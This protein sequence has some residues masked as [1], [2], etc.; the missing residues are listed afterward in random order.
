MEQQDYFSIGKI[1]GTHGLSGEVV[2]HHALG[3]DADLHGLKV[4]FF[5]DKKGS[6]LPYFVESVIM[7]KKQEAHVKI[8][9]FTNPENAKRLARKEVWLSKPDFD[10]YTLRSAP[11]SMLGYQLMENGKNLGEIIEI[12]EQPMQILCKIMYSNNEALIPLHQE[13]LLKI[14]S[15]KK[16]VHVSLPDGLLDLYK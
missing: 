15:H 10:K 7:K 13:T 14:D 9:G 16:Q 5:E 2:L 12:I 1:V 8:E 6:F 3:E 11:I 4:I